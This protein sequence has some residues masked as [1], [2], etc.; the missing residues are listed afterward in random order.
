MI[1]PDLNVIV[2][3]YNRG[4]ASHLQAREWWETVLSS[5]RPV[6]L[7]WAVMLAFI[8]L[9]TQRRIFREPLPVTAAC[10]EVRAWLAQPQV[11]ILEPGRRHASI[12]FDLL[13]RLGTGGNLTTDAH[14]AALAIEHQCELSSTDADFTR[15]PGLQWMNPLR[16]RAPAGQ[17]P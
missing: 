9:A 11:V 12:V 2:H 17:A 15:F 10:D 13:E 3:A 14:L 7:C 1:L 6:G 5:S 8:R 4:S 16:R